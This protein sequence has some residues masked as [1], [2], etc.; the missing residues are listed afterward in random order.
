M[1]RGVRK[2]DKYKIFAHFA[3]VAST[4]AHYNNKDIIGKRFDV[5]LNEFGD[6]DFS[7]ENIDVDGLYRSCMCGYWY[8]CRM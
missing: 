1:P 8:S 4:T 6:F 3:Y 7:T 5:I 2:A